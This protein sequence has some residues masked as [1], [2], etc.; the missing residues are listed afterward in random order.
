MRKSAGIYAWF[1]IS[2][3]K[4]ENSQHGGLW[5]TPQPRFAA[6]VGQ[7]NCKYISPNAAA[8]HTLEGSCTSVQQ[9]RTP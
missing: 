6:K 3:A 2:P 1:S 5:A 7:N 9:R 4:F 8:L